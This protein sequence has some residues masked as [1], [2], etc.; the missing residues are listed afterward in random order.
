[1]IGDRGAQNVTPEK[2]GESNRVGSLIA[3]KWGAYVPSP[4]AKRRLVRAAVRS[5]S[6]GRVPK[7]QAPARSE[8]C[9]HF[10]PK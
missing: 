5:R 6:G 10:G 2:Q 3:P 1:M 7:G 8:V 4:T 9:L